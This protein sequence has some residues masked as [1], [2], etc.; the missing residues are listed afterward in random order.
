MTGLCRQEIPQRDTPKMRSETMTKKARTQIPHTPALPPSLFLNIAF[1]STLQSPYPFL[2]TPPLSPQFQEQLSSVFFSIF[3]NIK[4]DPLTF[5][6]A[7]SLHLPTA[8]GRKSMCCEHWL[9]CSLFSVLSLR[10]AP[11]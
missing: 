5:C 3:P 10:V 8:F 4:M 11:T 9:K 2:S 6:L 1:S 7:P